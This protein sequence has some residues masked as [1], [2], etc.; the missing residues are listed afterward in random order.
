MFTLLKNYDTMNKIE[1]ELTWQKRNEQ[2]FT[3]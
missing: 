1:M 3:M 2:V